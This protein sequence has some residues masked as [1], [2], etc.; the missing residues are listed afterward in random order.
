MLGIR[1]KVHTNTR[2]NSHTLG[3]AEIL[4]YNSASEA[5]K[6]NGTNKMAQLKKKLLDRNRFYIHHNNCAVFF[7]LFAK[8]VKDLILQ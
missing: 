4:I 5:E 7:F 6:A 2:P 8:H 1:D 3:N